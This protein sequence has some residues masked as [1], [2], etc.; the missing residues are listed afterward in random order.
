[1][2]ETETSYYKSNIAELLKRFRGRY[3]VISGEQVVGDFDNMEA[4]Y[5]YAYSKYA[6]GS[7]M[8]QECTDDP[9]KV[10]RRFT[11]R[12]FVRK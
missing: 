10:M 4:A 1:M 5:K 6:P 12:V 9:K 11:S 7:F 8:V 3:L 2:L